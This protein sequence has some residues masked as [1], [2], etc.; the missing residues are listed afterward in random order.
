[1]VIHKTHLRLRGAKVMRETVESAVLVRHARVQTR[2]I[3]NIQVRCRILAGRRNISSPRQIL[4]S[5]AGHPWQTK[6]SWSGRNFRKIQA[7]ANR[8]VRKAGIVLDPADALLGHGKQQFAVAGNAR[9][10]IVHLRIVESD[11]DH[12]GV[13]VIFRLNATPL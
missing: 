1:M 3:Q 2:G 10:G 4:R 7:C 13:R 11:C 8:M 6:S 9:R 5:G 12:R